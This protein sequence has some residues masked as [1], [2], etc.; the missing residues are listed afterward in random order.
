MLISLDETSLN[1]QNKKLI[2]HNSD[3]LSS[4]YLD[5]TTDKSFFQFGFGGCFQDKNESALR[6]LG[7]YLITENFDDI[8]S[9][10]FKDTV[11]KTVDNWIPIFTFLKRTKSILDLNLA[12]CNLT[13]K[14]VL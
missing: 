9:L 1:H 3:S 6:Y 10:S 7:E 2:R 8:I 12:A 5:D 4:I 11:L 14:A 13:D